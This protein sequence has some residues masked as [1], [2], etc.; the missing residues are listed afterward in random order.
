MNG[1]K[2]DELKD[3]LKVAIPTKGLHAQQIRLLKAVIPG[4]LE[5]LTTERE[6]IFFTQSKETLRI[7][8]TMVKL[9]NFAEK[10]SGS[11]AYGNQAIEYAIDEIIDGIKSKNF[12]QLDN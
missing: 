3:L 1:L 8:A 5:I 10:N 6:D 11:L 2:Y 7:W 4:L 12:I 9:S